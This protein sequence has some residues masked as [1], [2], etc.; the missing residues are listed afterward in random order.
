VSKITRYTLPNGLI[1]FFYINLSYVLYFYIGLLFGAVKVGL[2]VAHFPEGF[3]RSVDV[4]DLGL[5]R[6]LHLQQKGIA[7]LFYFPGY[8]LHKGFLDCGLVEVVII[9]CLQRFDDLVLDS[10]QAG[11]HRFQ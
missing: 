3:G 7:Y 8:G 9:D 4:A 10:C 6:I 2:D 11:D 1:H 5:E